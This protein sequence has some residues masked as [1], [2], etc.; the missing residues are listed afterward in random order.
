MRDEHDIPSDIPLLAEAGREPGAD[1]PD[2]GVLAV[3]AES[4]LEEEERN[5]LEGHLADCSHC[6]GQVGFLV[7][8]AEAELPA[9]PTDL[10]DATR[11]RGDGRSA[12][13]SRAW[14]FGPR[15]ASD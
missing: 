14:P 3:Y 11:H 13:R 4:A 12:A 6:L 9:V 5:A 2:E 8:A 1:C 15:I 7:R 10:L